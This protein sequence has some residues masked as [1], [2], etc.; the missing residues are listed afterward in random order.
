MDLQ[1]PANI[2][3]APSSSCPS[4]RER[5]AAGERFR[6]RWRQE[7]QAAN[8]SLEACLDRV[9]SLRLASFDAGDDFGSAG[10][11]DGVGEA[12]ATQTLAAPAT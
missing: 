3:H 8:P 12:V 4:S 11:L 1:N 7:E 10:Y 5:G 9:H 6:L 2:R